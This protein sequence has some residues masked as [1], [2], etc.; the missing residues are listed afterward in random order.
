MPGICGFCDTDTKTSNA[1]LAA[2]RS[3]LKLRTEYVDEGTYDGASGVGLARVSLGFINTSAQP[4]ILGGL[5]GVMDGELYATDQIR[6]KLR[7]RGFHVNDKI[8]QLELLLHLYA[9][10]DQSLWK[11][12]HGSFAAAIWD[13]EAKRL[14]LLNDRF[15]SRPLYYARF[16]GRLLFASSIASILTDT[17]CPRDPSWKGLAQFFT[18]GHYLCDH[19][20]IDAIRVLPAAGWLVYEQAR[21]DYQLNKYWQRDATMLPSFSSHREWLHHIDTAFVRAVERRTSGEGIGMSL[22]GGLDARSILGVIDVERVQLKTICLGMAGSLDHRSAAELAKLVG[23]EHHNH[24]LDNNFLGNFQR[25]MEGM[26]RLTDGQYLSQ[27]IVMPTLPLYQHLGVRILLRGHAG[28][29]MHMAKAYNYSVDENTLRMKTSSEVEVW[30]WNRLQAF[31]LNGVDTPLFNGVLSCEMQ[32]LSRDS[33]RTDLSEHENVSPAVQQIWHCFVSQRLRRETT[34]S[35]LKFRSVVEP[36]VP[37]LDNDLIDLLLAAPPELKMAEEIQSHILRRHRPEFLQVVNANTGARMG[38][39]AWERKLATLRMKIYAKLGVP[40]YQPY[41]RLGLWLRRELAPMVQEILF[42][43][44]CL[45][46]GLFQA[47]GVRAVVT[48]HLQGRRN[49][50]FLLM[51]MMICELGQRI[52][53]G[54]A[55]VAR[56]SDQ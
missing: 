25:H 11:D 39:A 15:G 14:V 13:G 12:V 3:A 5:R 40:G 35:L 56:N 6:I 33:L 38:A 18:F 32:S 43:D 44:Q 10:R 27:C 49:H 7:E 47:D 17:D 34:L 2:M 36:R 19:T 45:S 29:L 4:G 52:L 41:E 50:T 28:E 46:R 42:S 20:S 1:T 51:A 22:S 53:M 48:N 37:I 24:V 26:V 54:E 16:C 21:K 30:L 31:M 9:T 23:T 55:G 8:T